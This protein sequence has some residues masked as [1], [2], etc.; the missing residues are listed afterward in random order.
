[1]IRFVL[2]LRSVAIVV[3]QHATEPLAAFGLARELSDFISRIDDLVFESL[4]VAFLVCGK[5][6]RPPAATIHFTVAWSIDSQT[7][8]SA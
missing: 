3:P 8:W 5:N 4:V 7:I 2:S 6:T 1:M